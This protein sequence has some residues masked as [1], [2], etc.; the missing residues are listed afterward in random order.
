MGKRCC[1]NFP[2]ALPCGLASFEIPTHARVG[3][4][5]LRAETARLELDTLELLVVGE[6][7]EVT[8]PRI[9]T[10]HDGPA[11]RVALELSADEGDAEVAP[12]VHQAHQDRERRLGLDSDHLA[13]DLVLDARDERLDR[14]DGIVPVGDVPGDD[15][16]VVAEDL[17]QVR[18]AIIIEG[19]AGD[20]DDVLGH[21]WLLGWCDAWRRGLKELPSI[22]GG[23]GRRDEAV[24]IT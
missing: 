15:G 11:A 1:C 22:E 5:R 17:L 23:V 2:L 14:G 7:E 13:A 3:Q 21:G 8:P 12:V 19:V 16:D 24:I 6:L 10:D 4:C 9:L 18:S 20:A